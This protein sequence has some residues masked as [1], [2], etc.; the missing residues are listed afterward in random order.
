MNDA[1]SAQQ[2]AERLREEVPGL[3]VE[4]VLR[5]AST[6]AD[7]LQRLPLLD[8]PL[9]LAAEEQTAGRGRA[10]RSWLA[11]PHASL[12]FSLA[13]PFFRRDISGLLGLPLAVGVAVAGALSEFGIAA[14]LKWPNDIQLGEAKLGGILIET[15]LVKKA[16]H[17]QPWAVIG[18]GLNIALTAEMQ[19]RIGR[20]AAH[21]PQLLDRRNALLAALAGRLADMLPR[22]DADGFAPFADSWNQLHAHAGKEVGILDD[23]RPARQGVAVGVDQS[24]RLL[25]DTATGR[26][27][28][29]AGDVSLRPSP[30]PGATAGT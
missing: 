8:A 15:G 12:T 10:G 25:L 20:E 4:C 16:G 21:M 3:Q 6:N 5:T 19:S 23:G 18:I 27:A 2:I 13:W 1:L 26:I 22:F 9:L 11:Q 14:T 24:G 28:V 29:T 7:L 30:V 17:R